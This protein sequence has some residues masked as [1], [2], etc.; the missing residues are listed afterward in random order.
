M[1]AI[2]S[3]PVYCNRF[4]LL[5]SEISATLFAPKVVWISKVHTYIQVVLK[6]LACSLR[7][8]AG[9]MHIEVR[10][11]PMNVDQH[12]VSLLRVS[13]SSTYLCRT[14]HADLG[15]C[16]GHL[17]LFHVNL[18]EYCM[19]VALYALILSV[20]GSSESRL[21][22]SHTTVGST[23]LVSQV[24]YIR[25]GSS[26]SPKLARVSVNDPGCASTLRRLFALLVS[27]LPTHVSST[28]TAV[29][30]KGA[31]RVSAT[32]TRRSA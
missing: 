13:R 29:H 30:K 17:T 31:S 14:I 4:F 8:A 3:G 27:R 28:I 19:L 1:K 25:S 16:L 5:S 18:L 12:R 7:K 32:R 23:R 11:K 6:V 2:F 21:G 15:R 22:R 26:A 20:E 9:R 10:E 24:G